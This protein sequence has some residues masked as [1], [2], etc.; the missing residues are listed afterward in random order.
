M[1]EHKRINVTVSRDVA[2]AVNQAVGDGEYASSGDVVREAL[3]DWTEKRRARAQPD[4]LKAFIA[5]GLAEEASGR[6]V[7]FDPEAVKAAGR[8]RSRAG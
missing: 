5:E 6:L 3:R 2:D 4:D 8:A 1:S 7:D